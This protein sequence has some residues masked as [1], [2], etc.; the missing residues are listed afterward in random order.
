MDTKNRCAWAGNDPL[1]M[2]YH[3]TEWGVPL[4]DDKKLFEFLVLEGAQAGLNWSCILNKRENY[5][6]A[7]DDFDPLKVGRYDG[8]KVAE[9]LQDKGIVRNKLKVEAAIRNARATLAIQEEFGSLDT[10]LWQFTGGGPMKNAW[11]T[12]GEIPSSTKESDKMSKE[13]KRRGFTFVGSTICYAFMQ[14]V[15]M[16]NDH[17]VDCFRYEEV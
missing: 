1:Y 13:L 3:D 15:G 5:R 10:F 9:L 7:F 2:G 4:H 11:K 8:G 17:V 6:K 14:A 16:V 12:L